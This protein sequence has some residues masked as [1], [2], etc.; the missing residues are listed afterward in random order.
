MFYS[1]ELAIPPNTLEG[2]PTELECNIA[3]GIVTRVIIT[4][5]TGCAKL[6][7]VKIMRSYHQVWPS[8][9]DGDFTADGEVLDFAEQYDVTDQPLTFKLVG[10]NDDDTYEHTIGVRLLIEANPEPAQPSMTSVI[11]NAFGIRG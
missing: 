7:H 8:N 11:R 10:W 9:P 6:A 2:L 5:P 1:Y 3:P 4:F